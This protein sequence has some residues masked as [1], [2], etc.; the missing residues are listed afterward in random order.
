MSSTHQS[1]HY[2]H[3]TG[4]GSRSHHGAHGIAGF[5]T[6]Q[7]V[8]SLALAAAAGFTLGGGAR[9]SG[10]LTILALLLQVAMREGNGESSLLGKLLGLTLGEQEN[11]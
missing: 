3:A 10:G 1:T 2:K 7:P 6:E 9:R 8:T 4:N 5:V 11:A